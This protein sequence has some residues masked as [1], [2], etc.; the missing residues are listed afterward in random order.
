M[1]NKTIIKNLSTKIFLLFTIIL[2]S[3]IIGFYLTI[4]IF[5]PDLLS[6]DQT[7]IF[8]TIMFIFLTLSCCDILIKNT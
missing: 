4:I 2:S 8:L 7:E 3:I 6:N 1:K 5:T